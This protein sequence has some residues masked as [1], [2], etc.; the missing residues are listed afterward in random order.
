MPSA[1]THFKFGREVI[2]LLPIEL[3]NIILKNK[4]LYE[5]GLQG[6]DILFFYK[7][8]SSP[9]NLLGY[10]IHDR[11]ATE[12]FE[13]AKQVILSMKNQEKALAY[14]F[15]FICHFVL[16]SQCHPYVEEK[17][18]QSGIS[19]IEIEVEWDRKLMIMD[20]RNPITYKSVNIINASSANAA[21]IA[22]F[23][24]P[25][26]RIQ[27][28]EALE[29]MKKYSNLFVAP[30]IF[31]RLFIFI[32]LKLIRK[33]KDLH[34]LVV[35]YKANPNCRDSCTRLDELYQ[36]A[37]QV[38]AMLITEYTEFIYNNKELNTRYLKTFGSN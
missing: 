31:K 14:L 19:H 23:F 12:F 16:D 1:Y 5:I 17:I 25:A 8:L 26:S 35:N 3:Q 15:G 36:S 28:Q 11:P 7:P 20:K 13:P 21:I 32:I 38:A 18:K 2:K 22:G 37:V 29:S 9:N 6:P 33:Y 4:D 10:D 24:P 30:G 27:I 34:G